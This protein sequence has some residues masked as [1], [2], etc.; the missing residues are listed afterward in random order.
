MPFLS[1]GFTLVG[2]IEPT[3]MA[4]VMQQIATGLAGI[5]VESPRKNS[6]CL[7]IP[8]HFLGFQR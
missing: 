7:Y 5:L 3:A 1:Y 2:Q 6:T 8:K 4:F